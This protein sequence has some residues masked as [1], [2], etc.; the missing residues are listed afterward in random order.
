[1]GRAAQTNKE[2]LALLLKPASP[3]PIKYGVSKIVP[4]GHRE[5]NKSPGVLQGSAARR[6]I[7]VPMC[8]KSTACNP[9][10]HIRSRKSTIK[11]VHWVQ[12]AI[13][14]CPGCNCR[15]PHPPWAIVL[16]PH[17]LYA[18]VVYFFFYQMVFNGHFRNKTY[19]SV[20]WACLYSLA[21]K[22][23]RGSTIQYGYRKRGTHARVF[24]QT[25]THGNSKNE[26]RQ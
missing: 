3:T 6:C 1:M 4:E 8:D 12:L 15:I 9:S 10:W 5:G 22:R 26:I 13:D 18:I 14:N 20:R 2:A 23:E 24:S 11:R 16:H 7:S 25:L 21:P 17:P 19:N